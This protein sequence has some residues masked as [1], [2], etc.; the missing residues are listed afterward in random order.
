MVQETSNY[1]CGWPMLLSLGSRQ[2]GGGQ[3]G[4]DMDPMVVEAACHRGGHAAEEERKKRLRSLVMLAEA[5]RVDRCGGDGRADN[6]VLNHGDDM[7]LMAVEAVMEASAWAQ[8]HRGAHKKICQPV[9]I[10]S[11]SSG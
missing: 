9:S 3:G 10:K 6:V 4:T 11:K 1:C 8:W 5:L 2:C 7:D